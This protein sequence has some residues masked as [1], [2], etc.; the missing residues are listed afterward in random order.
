MSIKSIMTTAALAIALPVVASAATFDLTGPSKLFSQ[1]ALT[2]TD[3]ATGISASLFAG[4]HTGDNAPFPYQWDC[5]TC[6]AQHGNGVSVKVSH[7]NTHEIDNKE[8]LTFLFS[9]NVLLNSVWLNSA[10]NHDEWDMAVDNHDLSIGAL[11]GSSY[12]KSGFADGLG[13]PKDDLAATGSVDYLADFSANG[14]SLFGKSFT[15]YTNGYFDDYKIGALDFSEVG[16]VPLPA[17]AVLLLTGFG[18]FG[19]MRAR[20]KA[21]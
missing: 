19:A 11:F 1:G 15:F 5:G 20:K 16:A 9:E 21:A 12:I 8:Y 14:G 13:L 17:G 18:A 2:F 7:D 4:T 6:V 10:D 3:D